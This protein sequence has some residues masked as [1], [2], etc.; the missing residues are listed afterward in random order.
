M[1]KDFHYDERELV[2]DAICG[3]PVPYG[4]V[5]VTDP[6]MMVTVEINSNSTWEWDRTNLAKLTDDGLFRLYIAVKMH[7]P[8]EAESNVIPFRFG[9][10]H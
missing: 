10:G 5:G 6:P 7:N 2:I 4:G 9:R 8:L 3:N 1:V